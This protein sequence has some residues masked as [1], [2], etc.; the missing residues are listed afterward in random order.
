MSGEK[1][2]RCLLRSAF[3]GESRYNGKYCGGVYFV[4][5]F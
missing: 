5:D 1:F 3:T 4:L 2:T